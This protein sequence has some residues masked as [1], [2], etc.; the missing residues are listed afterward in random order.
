MTPAAFR[1]LALSMPD[2]VEGS[3]Q[4]HPD[5]RAAGRVFAT[6]QP[7]GR[8]G[9]VKGPPADQARLVKSHAGVFEPATGAWGRAGCT[10]VL[11]ADADAKVLKD[12]MTLAWQAAISARP[13]R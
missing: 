2:A 4:G 9:M 13:R 11:L 5:F 8:R 3:H 12:A 7:D 6:L 1:K 10:M